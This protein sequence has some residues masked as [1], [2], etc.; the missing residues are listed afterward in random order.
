MWLFYLNIS[1][2]N[3]NWCYIV[4]RFEIFKLKVWYLMIK[5]VFFWFFQNGD[6]AL[7]ISAAMGRRKLTRVLLESNCSRNVRNK[8][9]VVFVIMLMLLMLMCLMCLMLLWLLL[10]LLQQKRQEQGKTLLF[11]FLL[12]FLLLMFLL[13]LL[14]V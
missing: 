4:F 12:M 6:T 9:F 8:V 14:V 1:T 13:L 7:H 11:L 3:N 5:C 10:L 2:I